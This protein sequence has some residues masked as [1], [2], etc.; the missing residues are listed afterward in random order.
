MISNS[1]A[2]G[3]H[4]HRHLPSSCRVQ[5]FP[6]H[7]YFFHIYD[8][9][10]NRFGVFSDTRT[11][12]L[13]FSTDVRVLY[14]SDNHYALLLL[15]HWNSRILR[16][17]NSFSFV[18]FYHYA[19][20]N[21]QRHHCDGTLHR[22]CNRAAFLTIP[23]TYCALYTFLIYLNDE[24]RIFSIIQIT[25][26][27]SFPSMPFVQFERRRPS[28]AYDV[29]HLLNLVWPHILSSPFEKL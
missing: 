3:P 18:V 24:I 29:A 6:L 9:S 14:N 23:S 25:K 19:H 28:C 10:T 27:V 11:D 26:S 12:P 16:K 17:I 7:I 8:F 13:L 20:K 15:C 5:P 1:A 4:D 21:V 22:D 2:L